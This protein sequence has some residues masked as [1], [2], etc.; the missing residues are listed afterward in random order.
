MIRW[1]LLITCLGLLAYLILAPEPFSINLEALP[2]IVKLT[3]HFTLFGI[4]SW[5]SLGV[6]IRRNHHTPWPPIISIATG[7]IILAALGEWAQ[8]HAPPRTASVADLGV[9][10]MGVLFAAAVWRWKARKQN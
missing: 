3:G 10:A 4:L 6:A 5:L 1:L 8:T 9:G 7:L 2:E